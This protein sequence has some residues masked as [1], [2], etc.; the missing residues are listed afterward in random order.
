MAKVGFT[1]LHMLALASLVVGNQ[2]AWASVCTDQSRE[3]RVL[4]LDGKS[5]VHRCD[6]AACIVAEA[7]AG[8]TAAVSDAAA[9]EGKAA[10]AA[11]DG[12]AKP[13]GEGEEEGVPDEEEEEEPAM[14][15]GR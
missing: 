15:G 9:S 11:A 13:D 2:A 4:G 7:E 1:P 6:Q 3:M 12:P 14:P 10:K 5:Q 8:V